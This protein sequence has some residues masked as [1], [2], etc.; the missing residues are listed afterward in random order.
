LLNAGWDRR[1]GD[2]RRG[3]REPDPHHPIRAYFSPTGRLRDGLPKLNRL[4]AGQ[5]TNGA[6]TQAASSPG[7]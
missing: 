5:G 3:D 7:R 1:G 6:G 2:D 4:P